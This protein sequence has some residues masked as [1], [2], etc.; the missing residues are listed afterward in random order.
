MTL[1]EGVGSDAAGTKSCVDRWNGH[2]AS[3]GSKHRTINGFDVDMS[4]AHVKIDFEVGS[5]GTIVSTAE[6]GIRGPI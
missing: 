5:C 4:T 1:E 3:N 2:H 6:K